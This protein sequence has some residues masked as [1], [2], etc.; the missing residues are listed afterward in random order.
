MS[1]TPHKFHYAMAKT[2]I[3]HTFY[4]KIF[5]EKLNKLHNIFIINVIA[6]KKTYFETSSH[7]SYNIIVLSMKIKNLFMHC[8][9][10]N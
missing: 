3:V 4:K 9:E 5:K 10:V 6:Q 2:Q 8:G 7:F 1:F